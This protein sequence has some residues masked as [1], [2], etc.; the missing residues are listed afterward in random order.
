MKIAML[1]P[2]TSPNPD[3]DR[4]VWDNVVSLLNEGLVKCGIEVTLF[5][6]GDLRTSDQR[7][8]VNPSD[9][10][11]RQSFPARVRECLHLSE[12][13]T[14]GEQ[15]DLIHNHY[16]CLP[17][18]YMGM[19]TTPVVVTTHG[20]LSPEILTVY[21]KYNR[22]A[23]YVAVSEADKCP[24]LDYIDTI[25][26]GIDLR[27]FSFRPKHGEY[28]L[29]CGQIKDNNGAGECIEVARR[30]GMR[31]LLAGSIEDQDY[32]GRYVLP[33]LDGSRITYAGSVGWKRDELFGN[34]YALL[35]PINLDEPF[36]R[37]VVEAMACGTPVI[38]M[39][40]GSMTE[41]IIDGATGFLVSDLNEMA[42]AVAKVAQLNRFRCR[43]WIEE[44]FSA[45]RMVQDYIRVYERIIQQTRRE[46][47][48]PWGF[49]EILSDAP[50]H[51]VKRI[52]VYPGQR[53]SYQRHFRRSEHWYVIS[54]KAVV[55]RDGKDIALISGQAV[56]LP[57]EIWHRMRN[58]GTENMVFIEVQTGEYFGE[59][60][61][62]RSEDDYGRA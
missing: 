30:T 51:K 1:S 33:Q 36:E 39:N 9:Y 50:D 59:D 32:F 5:A 10:D 11:E 7:L 16:D 54:G 19:T 47:H 2:A 55:T 4:S 57:V 62:E 40:R 17:L 38:A 27:R 3:T 25:P 48:R 52:T 41:T 31:L 14:R 29:F 6:T 12:V 23:F 22:K 13:F 24:E 8:E 53:L 58:P 35:H 60:D 49:Y 20:L 45:D 15:F 61:I 26:P 56:D 43:E 46:D 37:S 42:G 21:K 18:T 44:R 34:A 28:L